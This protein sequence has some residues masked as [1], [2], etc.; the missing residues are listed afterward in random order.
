MADG[1][2]FMMV[3]GATTQI[4]GPLIQI[5]DTGGISIE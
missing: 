4:D 3:G 2:S 5:G 1:G